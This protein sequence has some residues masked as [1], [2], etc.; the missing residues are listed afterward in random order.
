MLSILRVHY[1]IING[2]KIILS[3]KIRNNISV[4]RDN[5]NF[6]ATLFENR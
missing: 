2:E 4:R 1:A 3:V 6:K 5:C